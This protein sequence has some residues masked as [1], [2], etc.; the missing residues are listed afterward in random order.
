[1]PTSDTT[2][3]GTTTRAD[4]VARDRRSHGLYCTLPV[5]SAYESPDEWQEF[6]DAIL[7]SLVPEGALEA[8]LASR[9]AAL[10]WRL[11][12]APVAEADAIQRRLDD[13]RERDQ[14]VETALAAPD[15][16]PGVRF[17]ASALRPQPAGNAPDPAALERIIRME[18]HLNR[19]LMQTLHE[20]EALQARRR[21]ER[22]PLAR[23]DVHG[24]P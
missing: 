5:A 3:A 19:Q 8:S 13:Y 16:S 14:Q 1:M 4:A 23:I 11:R 9:A 12:R 7:D 17:Y 20:L 21:G 2:S 24:E 18:A 15:L 6:H 22:T 10:C